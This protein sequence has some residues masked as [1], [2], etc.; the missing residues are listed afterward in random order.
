M[1]AGGGADVMRDPVHLHFIDDP[2]EMR[3]NTSYGTETSPR[4]FSQN[5]TAQASD[6]SCVQ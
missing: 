3:P 4:S 6:V 2:A 1:V 5:V